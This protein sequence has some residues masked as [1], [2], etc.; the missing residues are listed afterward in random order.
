MS[1]FLE[2]LAKEI[3]VGDGGMGSML[4][5]EILPPKGCLEELCLSHPD[6]VLGVHLKYIQAGA[7]II[8]TN[9]F[10]ATRHKL[11][12][13]GLADQVARINGAAVKLAREA[14]EIS[15]LDVF[16]AGSVGPSWHPFDPADPKSEDQIRS[17]FR[18]QAEALDGRGVDLFIVETF[19][20]LWEIGRAIEGIRSVSSLPIVA[21]MTFSADAWEEKE[22]G[23]E[24]GHIAAQLRQL[25]ADVIGSNCSVGPRDMLTILDGLRGRE[26]EPIYVAPNT[27]VPKMWEGRFIYPDSSP[28]YFAWFA[29]EAARRGA[30]IIAGCCGTTPSHIRAVVEAVA[31]LKPDEIGKG[32]VEV[33]PPPPPASIRPEIEE[34]V[35]ARKLAAHE[36]VVSIQID[37]P[38]GTNASALLDAV[39]LFKES[40]RVDTVDI[41][42][43]PL[44][45]LHM[46]SLWMAIMCERLG[47]ET[48]PHVTARDSSLMGIEASLLGAWSQGVRNL[49][50]ITGDP[51][52][53]GDLPGKTDVYQTDAIGLVREIRDL[54]RGRDCGGNQVGDPPNFLLGVAVNPTEP[55]IER[56]I[57]RFRRK[58]D[59]GAKFAMTQVFFDWTYWERFLK[60][61]GGPL[62]IP[63][64]VAV[65][66]L[67]SHKLAMRLHNEVPGIIVPKKIQDLLEKAGGNAR[68][69]GFA[70]AREILQEARRREAGVYIIAPFKSPATALELLD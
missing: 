1:R 36:F 5:T 6:V 18:E 64:L 63:V 53:S 3:L 9:S 16:I 20:S 68:R 15:G 41:N 35:L 45:H 7:R 51:S 8:E 37:P 11:A 31:G 49:L 55:N 61:Y 33:L 23:P 29:R 50:V 70:L 26:G 2:V 28:E 54:N 69:E 21:N 52:Q 42:S 59:S 60:L 46:D 10:G 58:V 17:L 25:G 56:E 19:G 30:R 40:G 43:N 34:G 4:H 39:R 62:P 66:P 12:S 14:R 65:W 67:T 57:E 13:L 44:A 47:I 38:K 22:A 32:S 27:G 24:P 48:I